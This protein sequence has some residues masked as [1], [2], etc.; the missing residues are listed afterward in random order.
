METPPNTGG[1]CSTCGTRLNAGGSCLACLLRAGMGE[2]AESQVNAGP[3][4]GDFEVARREDGSLWELGRGAMGVTFKAMDRILHRAVALKVVQLGSVDIQDRHQNAA[5]R[6]RFLREARAAAALRHANVAG[7]YQFG[8]SE[9]AD[10]CFYAM[11]LVEGETLEARVQRDGPLDAPTALEVGRQVCAALVAAAGRGLIHRDVKPGNL[12]L[13][14]AGRGPSAPVEVKVIDFG[15]AKAAAAAGEADLT[16]G[17]FVGTPAYASPE[18]FAREPVDARSDLYSLGITLWFALTGRV[19][20]TGRTAEELRHHPARS[21]LPVGQLHARKV[22]PPVVAL[23]RRFLAVEPAE[24]PATAQKGLAEIE[25]C[26]RR[27]DPRLGTGSGRRLA[28]AGWTVAAALALAAAGGWW[29]TIRTA[30]D[31]AAATA[32]AEKSLAVL[33]FDNFSPDKENAY[34]ADGIQDEVLTDLARIAD[35]KVISRTSV[36]LYKDADKRTNLREIGRAL[37]VTDRCAQVGRSL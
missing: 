5:L 24:R 8:A 37:G 30:P 28:A 23:L 11:E 22:P 36:M 31:R 6:E 20:F 29:K 14:S 2:S 17:G 33:P 26:L 34:F 10:R 19:P 21:K 18:Q 32:I 27:I 13:T 35:L 16:D 25:T 9:H 7:I 1:V 15:L 3:A 4:Y 12:M